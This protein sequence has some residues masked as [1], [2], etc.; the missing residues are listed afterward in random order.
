MLLNHVDAG[1]PRDLQNT[2]VVSIRN[3]HNTSPVDWTA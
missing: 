3:L 2:G 1:I